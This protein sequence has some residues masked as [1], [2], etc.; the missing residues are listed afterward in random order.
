METALKDLT[1]LVNVLEE[2][3]FSIAL[4]IEIV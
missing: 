3:L 4:P 1:G 2:M